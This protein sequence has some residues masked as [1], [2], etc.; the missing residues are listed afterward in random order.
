MEAG[1]VGLPYVGKTTIFKALT[2][3]GAAGTDAARPNV[4]VAPV[5]DP[6]LDVI[7]R[8]IPP[9][10]I[11]PATLQVVDVAGL[12]AGA[13]E[14]KGGGNRFLAHIRN[15]DALVHVVRAFEDPAVPHVHD[16][17]DPVRDIEEVETEL[18]LADLEVVE[19]ALA[20]ARKKA[21]T[22]AKDAIAR[23]A[24]LEQCQA[25]LSE[26]RPV[27]Q[28]DLTAEQRKDLASLALLS[29]KPVLYVANIG[30]DEIGGES[31]HAKGVFDYAAEHGGQAAAVCAKLEAELVDIDPAE[32]QEMLEA[33]GL[34][35]PALNVLARATFRLLG[36][37]SFFTAGPKEVRAWVCRR[38]AAA[39]EAAGVIH[40]DLERGFIR[41]EVYNVD[42]LVA[43]G[44]EAAIKAAGKMRTEG[45]SYVVRDSDVCHFLFNI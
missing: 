31:A 42:D 13:S 30:E 33:M 35:E 12:A 45:K 27:R 19:N 28:L 29:A 21:R 1:I 22:G 20:N 11:T 18:M 6:R 16:T 9:K 32:R 10:K 39:P 14:G 34:E 5:P 4:G 40:S 41:L 7:A 2:A 23:V 8:Y 3:L 36:L 25:A 37:H 38:G 24:A 26:G 17:I 15:V 44:S 43:H